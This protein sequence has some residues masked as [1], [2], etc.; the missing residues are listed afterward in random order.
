[1]YMPAIFNS[2]GCPAD[3]FFWGVP[4]PG[5]HGWNNNCRGHSNGHPSPCMKRVVWLV[6]AVFCAAMAQVKPVDGLGAKAKPCSCCHPGACGM[7]GCCASTSTACSPAQVE[8]VRSLAAPRRAQAAPGISGTFY[9]VFVE[10]IAKG[11]PLFASARAAPAAS[12][13]I[14]TAHCSLLI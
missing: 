1:M 5:F 14:F 10:P 4:A 9:A 7:P 2:P 3:N 8:T 6:L 11:S 12:V 13:P